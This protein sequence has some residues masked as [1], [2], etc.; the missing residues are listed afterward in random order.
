METAFTARKMATA[1]LTAAVLCILGPWSLPIGPVPFSLAAFGVYLSAY[2]LGWRLAGLSY[3][4][5]LILGLAGV[6]VFTGFTG[7]LW[8]LAGPTGGYLIGM[9]PMAVLIGLAAEKTNRRTLPCCLAMAVGTLLNY[10]FGTAWF[11]V[12]TGCGVVYA[13]GICVAPFVVFDGIKIALALALGTPLHRRLRRAG[14][15]I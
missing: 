11:C 2:L 8:R 10:L 3:L 6:P 7:G 14:Y 4:C 12:Q 5:Y 1:A 9:L 13:L 15:I